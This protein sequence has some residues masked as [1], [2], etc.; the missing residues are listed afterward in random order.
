MTLSCWYVSFSSCINALCG[1][2]EVC[3]K[4]LW[5]LQS[6]CSF[7]SDLLFVSSFMLVMCI[8]NS[9]EVLLFIF[10]FTS[11]ICIITD[12]KK[13]KRKKKKLKVSK[14]SFISVSLC[15]SLFCLYLSMNQSVSLC[16]SLCMH[17][18]MH[19]N[20]PSHFS[21]V[22]HSSDFLFLF[23]VGSEH[24]VS[25]RKSCEDCKVCVLLILSFVL[26]LLLC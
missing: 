3:E 13:R 10:I 11:N 25:V 22:W 8:L 15:M 23:P 14:S 12:L 26:F 16:V 7:K 24:L 5:K 1:K 9:T 4:E 20:L 19:L 2:R 6:R 18:C 21:V 17:L